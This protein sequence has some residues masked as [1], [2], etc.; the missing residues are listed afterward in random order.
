MDPASHSGDGPGTRRVLVIK[1]SSLGDVIHTLPALTDA[2][3]AVPGVVFDWVVE[4]SLAEIPRWHRAVD[5][6]LPVAL[7]RW[8]KGWFASATRAERAAFLESLTERTY[9]TVIEAQGLV[10]SAWIA[11]QSRGPRHG[12]SWKSAR[13]PLASLALHHRHAIPREEHAIQRVRALFACALDYPMPDSP[14]DYGIDLQRFPA[15][16]GARPT[17]VFLHGTTWATKHWPE[18]HWI[19]LAGLAAAAGF[20]VLLPW[21]SAGEQARAQRIAAATPGARV[22]DRL[23]LD[24]IAGILAAAHGVVAVD[25]GLAHVA[26]ALGTPAVTLYGATKPGLT[27]TVGRNQAQLHSRFPCAPCLRRTCS[28]K[29]AS[30][31]QPACYE[32]LTPESVWTTLLACIG[33]RRTTA[34]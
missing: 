3:R 32:E 27:G 26:A 24:A 9:D 19:R 25:T 12:L 16:A 22:L 13:E 5:R 18:P 17:V 1:T 6:V 15:P 34:G 28:F 11:L 14:A 29:G 31:V 30:R 7:R 10:K 23:G 8:R 21:G 33:A 4:E 2:A 20:E